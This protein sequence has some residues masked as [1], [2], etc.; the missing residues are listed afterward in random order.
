M[1]R[2][3]VATN[4]KLIGDTP[5]RY[6]LGIMAFAASIAFTGCA[7]YH[8]KEHFNSGTSATLSTTTADPERATIYFFRQRAWGQALI[9]M[10]IPPLYYAIDGKLVSIMPLA[11]H[12]RFSLP[13]GQ[14]TFS[15]LIVSGG[16]LF[17][18]KVEA[19]ENTITVEAGKIYYIGTT[20]GFPS[21]AFGLVTKSQGSDIILDT[22]AARIL[23]SPLT[24]AAFSA[25]I[26]DLNRKAP[27]PA[28]SS[29]A[30]ANSGGSTPSSISDALPSSKQVGDFLEGL[31]A[32][33][34]IGLVI[35]AG[36]AASR[37]GANQYASAPIY[38]PS[39]MNT[40]PYPSAQ[41]GRANSG[42]QYQTQTATVQSPASWQ[43]SSGT[44][45]DILQSK[46]RVTL[47]NISTGVSYEIQD[48]R[49]IGT[50]GSRF[51]VHGSNIFSDTGQTY[52]VIGNQLFASDGKSCVKTGSIVS[53]D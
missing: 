45:S 30:G 39:P 1:E 27:T 44:L 19:T 18:R 43:N 41:Q 15:R 51:T 5:M 38:A 29:G 42:P 46:D 11:S 53:C 6:R 32:V 20:N 52:Q 17:D 49:I 9:Y 40:A 14:H 35:F 48:G 26:A 47:R 2:G 28:S 25:R 31:A 13:P 33:A 22:S 16:G 10:P 24:V 3:D 23:H 4:R 21:Q 12:V 8:T 34:L 50:D 36:A 37:S 7:N